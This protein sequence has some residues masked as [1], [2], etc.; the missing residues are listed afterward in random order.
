MSA[1]GDACL[2]GPIFEPNDGEDPNDFYYNEVT[3]A[4]DDID[5]ELSR[6]EIAD[7]DI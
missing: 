6:R 1:Y 2:Y 5:A 7:G 3:E 4:E